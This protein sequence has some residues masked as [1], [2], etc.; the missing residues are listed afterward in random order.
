[1]NIIIPMAGRGDRFVSAGYTDPKPLIKVN[2]RYV[3]DYVLDMYD[4]DNDKFTFICNNDHL[5]NTDMRNI[6]RGLAKNVIVTGMEQHKLGPV[7]TVL[8]IVDS[9][10]EEEPAIVSYCDNPVVWDYNQ[11]KR[12]VGEIGADGCLI[13]HSGFHPHTLSP[14][15]FAYSKTDAYGRVSEVKEKECFTNNRFN[16]HASSGVYYFKYGHYIKKYFKQL[17]NENFNYNG[18]FYVT[19]VFNLLVRDGLRVFSYLNDYVLAFGTPNE[20]RNFEAWQT[21]LSGNQIHNEEELVKCYNYWLNYKNG[22][23]YR[24]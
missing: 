3:V 9:I 12:Y 24:P 10:N 17:I 11:F 16:E 2:N 20:V 18:E 19:L 14:T 15:M 4:R 1:M 22:V 7:Y 5:Y 21:I 23:T 6:L 8:D 13:S